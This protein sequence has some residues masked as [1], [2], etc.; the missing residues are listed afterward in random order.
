MDTWCPALEPFKAPD[1]GLMASDELD[2]MR[3]CE[4][5]VPGLLAAL[6]D[7]NRAPCGQRTA[8]HYE[9]ILPPGTA[10]DVRTR[11]IVCR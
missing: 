7:P 1:S 10:A 2:A 3:D 6:G 11:E 5:P 4:R 8:D 9:P